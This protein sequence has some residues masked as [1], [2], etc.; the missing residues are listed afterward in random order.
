MVELAEIFR[1]FGPAYREKFGPRLLPSHRR[2]MQAIESC[3]TEAL[4]GHVYLC[5][6]CEQ[7]RYRYHS[8]KNRHCPKCQQ[9][10]TERWLNQQQNLRL[11]V[12]YFLLTFTLPGA[13]RAIARR[14]QRRLYQ[15][16]FR[17]SAEA[18]QQLARD[19]RFVGGQ[20][21]LI[22]VLQ[23][24]SR[25]LP[26]LADRPG[27]YH[28]HIHYLV[29]GG[30]LAGEGRRWLPSRKSFFLPVKALS[31]LFR[32]K[33]RDG[34]RKTDWL[35]P[36]PKEVWSQDW[37]VHCQPV[38]SGVAALKYLAPYIFRVALSN[39]RLRRLDGDQISFCYKDSRS[40]EARSCT[41]S[42]E[43]LIR[44]FL[45]HVLPKGFVKVRYYGF[46]P[47]LP[48]GSQDRQPWPAPAARPAAA[49]A[50]RV[51][52][53]RALRS[54]RPAR[55]I[56]V[57]LSDLWEC[58]AMATGL[59]TPR[60]SPAAVMACLDRLTH[61]PPPRLPRRAG[62]VVSCPPWRDCGGRAGLSP[63]IPRSPSDV[64][65][66]S[67]WVGSPRDRYNHHHRSN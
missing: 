37:V 58:H 63:D 29:P 31:V 55:A 38:G 11:P 24:W 7:A 13:L 46:F 59:A 9:Q 60:P 52:P 44:R 1:R 25:D 10:D 17:A 5:R 12:P 23:T 47:G 42:A 43:E 35:G 14:H 2:A 50:G 34:L 62:P 20:V 66:P 18:T 28:P 26:V 39:R 64:L 67:S 6:E 33:V 45:Q 53:G 56:R 8:C 19:P 54:A 61:R 16:L 30:G 22:G 48:G 40:G 41:L 32:A 36:V 27:S 49:A 51:P 4:G 21:G 3:R 15:L 57:A 65:R